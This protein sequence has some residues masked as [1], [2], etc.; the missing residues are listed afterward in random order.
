MCSANVESVMRALIERA[1]E[2]WFSRMMVCDER[3]ELQW[4]SK[5]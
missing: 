4:E 3:L 1:V 5:D 2:L